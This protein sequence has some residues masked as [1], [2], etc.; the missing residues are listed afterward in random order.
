MAASGPPQRADQGDGQAA[1]ARCSTSSRAARPIPSDVEGSGDVKYHLGASSDRSFDGNN[2]PPVADRQ[3]V[4]SRNRQ[5]GGAGQGAREAGLRHPRGQ[6]A[7]RTDSGRIAPSAAAADAR[8]RRLCRSGRGSGNASPCPDLKGYRTGGTIH[9]IVNNQIG[10][11]TYSR[12]TR[13]P[14]AVS[15]GCGADDPCADLPCERRR[16]GSGGAFAAKYRDRVPPEIPQGLLSWTCSA[17]AATATTRATNR[18][19]P[20]R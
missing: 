4:A 19:S 3:P 20:S 12:A 9:F 16:S 2:D 18:A 15:V 7:S 1:I 5:S 13:A 10:F 17:I 11:T 14:V 6:R 8:R